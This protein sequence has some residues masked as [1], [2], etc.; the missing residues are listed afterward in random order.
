MATTQFK[1]AIFD[2]DGV[3]T[4]TAKVHSKAWEQMFNDFLQQYAEREE[5]PFLPFDPFDDYQKY[6]DGKPR[7]MGVKTFLESRSI[8]LPFGDPSDAPDKETVCGLG[9]RKNVL[10][11]DILKRD[12]P[13]VFDSSI[14]FINSLREEGIRVGVASSSKN[15]ALVLEQAGLL[16]LFDTRVDGQISEELEL[17]GKPDA[18]IFL[19]A[20]ERLN[21]RAG[22][23]VVIEDAI[24]GVQAG[25]NGNFGLTLGIARNADGSLL[26][27]F[28]ADIIIQDLSEICVTDVKEWFYKGMI[29]DGWNLTYVGMDPGDEI[30]RETLTTVGNGLIGNRGSFEGERSGFHHYPGTYIAGVFNKLPSM[31]EGRELWNNDFVNCPNWTLIEF[32]IG[33]G[34]FTSPVSQDM[35][36][37]SYVHN[38]NMQHA[39]MERSIVCK[40]K[41]GR[42]TRIHSQRLV[43]MHEP[44]LCAIKY[45]FTPVNYAGKITIRSSIDGNVINDGVPRYRELN[46]K[47]LEFVAAGETEDGIFLHSR[48]NHSKYGI[49]MSAKTFVHEN[50]KA[51]EVEKHVQRENWQISEVFEVKVEENKTLAV[52]KLVGIATN[53]MPSDKEPIDIVSDVLNSVKSFKT[54]LGPH[55]KN[56]ESL[57]ERA[58]IEIAGDRLIQKVARLHTYHL[59]VTASPVNVKLALD[60][61]MPARGLHGEAYRGHIFWDEVYIFPFYIRNFPEV[62][63]QL[64]MY[65]YNRLDGA[66]AYAKKSGYNGAMYPWQTADDGNEETQELHYNPESKKWDPDLSRRQ[67]HVSIAVFYNFWNYFRST[68]D[69]GFIEKH[70]A[71]VMLEIARFWAS[72]AKLEKKTGK[73]H[74]DGVMGPDE[75]HEKLPGAKDPGLR[76]NAY[77]NVMVVWLLERSLKLM[78]LLPKA[79][80]QGIMDKIGMSKKETDKWKE[81]IIKLNVVMQGDIISQFDGYMDLKEL[82]WDDYRKRYYSIGRMDRIL[83]AEGDSPDNYKVAKQADVL[84]MFYLLPA[85]EVTRILNQLGHKVKDPYELLEDNY[86][87]YEP[88]TSHG[89][90][91]SKVVHAVISSRIHSCGTPWD[92]FMEAMRSDIFDT[93]GGTTKEGVHTGVMAGT[94]DVIIR[95][96]AGL[97]FPDDIPDIQPDLPPHWDA[98]SFEVRHKH[99]IYNLELTKGAIKILARGGNKKTFP[100]K[101][102]KKEYELTA[103]K[104]REFAMN[105]K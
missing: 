8:K 64:L 13:E 83:K 60:A 74:I 18:D 32:K 34:E 41:V 89:S 46:Q 76:D 90:T 35:E 105:G 81:M 21:L 59:F 42:I 78:D 28:G 73:Y 47:H 2:L 75:F 85:K 25:R 94:L 48:T 27:R 91:L 88:R 51:I 39:L 53:L 96:F 68:D 37:L 101:V 5:T 52:D 102:H 11:Q 84:M 33:N 56:W 58:N 24:S 77:T 87:Y 10:F 36:I 40:D 50:G 6:V 92:W 97:E 104:K 66:R 43:S 49:L 86:N 103:G 29:Q 65:R 82:D 30:L 95:E 93:Q 9:N 15:C 98:L 22:E 45:E 63:R 67:R 1:G 54:A 69:L 80:L 62:V 100:V 4:A 38:L 79:A 19:T 12:G 23:C 26:S 61:G 55:A 3:V 71:E 16:D 7:Y 44:N 57:W 70:G 14:R 17:K 99:G 20:A 31:V 72:I